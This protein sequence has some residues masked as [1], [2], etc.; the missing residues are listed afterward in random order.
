MNH[1][2]DAELPMLTLYL[3]LLAYAR[4]SAQHNLA[5]NVSNFVEEAH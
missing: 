3:N 4:K 2:P 5:F 1:A